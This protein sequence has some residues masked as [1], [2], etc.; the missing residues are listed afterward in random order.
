[1]INKTIN[2]VK[3]WPEIAQELGVFSSLTDDAKESHRLL[4]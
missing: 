4:I 2:V 1:V 3:Q